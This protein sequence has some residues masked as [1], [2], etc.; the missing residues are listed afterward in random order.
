MVDAHPALG[1]H[2]GHERVNH[3][4]NLLGIYLM[5]DAHP[6]LGRHAGHERAEGHGAAEAAGAAA[7]VV[8][9]LPMLRLSAVAPSLPCLSTSKRSKPKSIKSLKI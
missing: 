4:I 3:F 8:Q 7:A 1:R 6:A 5:V 9:R 2:T